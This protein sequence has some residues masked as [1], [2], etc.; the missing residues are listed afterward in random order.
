[1]PP[2]GSGWIIGDRLSSFGS[3]PILSTL[4]PSTASG[5]NDPVGTV[6]PSYSLAVAIY[7]FLLF[8]TT[9]SQEFT[10]TV[11]NLSYFDCLIVHFVFC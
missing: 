1:M 3:L 7:F 8:G 9:L 2:G 4:I 5:S 10:G 6:G 11:D